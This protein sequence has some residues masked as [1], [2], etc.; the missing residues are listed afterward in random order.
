MVSVRG[1]AIHGWF[2]GQ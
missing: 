2:R 1:Y